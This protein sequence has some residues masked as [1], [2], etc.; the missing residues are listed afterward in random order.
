M[1]MRIEANDTAMQEDSIRGDFAHNAEWHVFVS[2]RPSALA[3]L[4]KGTAST[5]IR[6]W[7]EGASQHR[8]L[9]FDLQADV[10]PFLKNGASTTASVCARTPGVIAAALNTTASRFFRRCPRPASG[11]PGVCSWV[12]PVKACGLNRR[13]PVQLTV[14][15]RRLQYPL[16]RIE[17]QTSHPNR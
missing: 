15:Q 4:G 9:P 12:P 7:S 17:P 10:A 5:P 3:V 1:R 2:A 13:E 16:C 11:N 14:Q 6:R 8:C